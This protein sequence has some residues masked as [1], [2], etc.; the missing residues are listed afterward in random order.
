MATVAISP[1]ND[2]IC[3]E[4]FIA[5]PPARV[6]QALTDCRQMPLWWGQREMYRVTRFEA[7]VRPNGKWKSV[8][9]NV[10]GEAFEVGGEYLEVDP[11]H[12]LVQTWVASWTGTMATKVRWELQAHDDGT[13]VRITHSGF[14]GNIAAANDHSQ[15]WQ[16][17]LLWLS[18]YAEKGETI[19]TRSR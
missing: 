15:G 9:A 5:A 4:I 7:D 16:R 17:V 12:L 13:L 1:D 11:P 8:G 18:G 14:A 6:F 3:S 10:K 19:E 2:T